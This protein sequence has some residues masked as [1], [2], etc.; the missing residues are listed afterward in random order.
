LVR[1]RRHLAKAV[2]YRFL[3]S[4]VTA[5]VVFFLTGNLNISVAFFAL[6]S[7]GKIVLYYVHERV[8]YHIGWGVEHKDG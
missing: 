1:R 3:G 5:A 7:V 6:E 2:S 4:L 8:W